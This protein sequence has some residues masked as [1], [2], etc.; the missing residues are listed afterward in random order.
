[1]FVHQ[2]IKKSWG[3]LSTSPGEKHEELQ[4]PLTSGEWK[5]GHF[6]WLFVDP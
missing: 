5:R 6:P 4:L 2:G 1:M 3:G